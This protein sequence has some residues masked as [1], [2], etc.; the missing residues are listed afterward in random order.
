MKSKIEKGIDFPNYKNRKSDGVR[1]KFIHTL[2]IGDSFL[3][4]NESQ[5]NAYCKAARRKGL[6]KLTSEKQDDGRIRI[7]RVA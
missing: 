6:L 5:R 2:E 3:C 4:E 7:W 1:T